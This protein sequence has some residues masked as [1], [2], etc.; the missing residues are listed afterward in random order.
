MNMPRADVFGA[1]KSE[2]VKF[3]LDFVALSAM[4]FEFGVPCKFG[5]F[6]FY[7]MIL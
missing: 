3:L 4:W 5:A 2:L 1:F 6:D 7:V